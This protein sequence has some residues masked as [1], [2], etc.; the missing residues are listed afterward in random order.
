MATDIALDKIHM[1]TGQ[2]DAA[3][4]AQ[5]AIAG[6][7]PLQSL[8]PRRVKLAPL[9]KVLDAR[10]D[11]TSNDLAYRACQPG[12]SAQHFPECGAAASTMTRQGKS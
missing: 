6:V 12:G 4:V 8:R 10:R 1:Q 5:H 3:A 7:A 9:V 11:S 2:S